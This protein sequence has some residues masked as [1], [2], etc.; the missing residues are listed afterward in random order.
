MWF[1][2]TVYIGDIII[3]DY[4]RNY[5]NLFHKFMLITTGKYEVCIYNS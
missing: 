5:D 1:P 3:I 2:L 4:T